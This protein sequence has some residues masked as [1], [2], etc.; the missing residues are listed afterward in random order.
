MHNQIRIS[1][2]KLRMTPDQRL[3]GN[4]GGLDASSSCMDKLL[5]ILHPAGRAHFSRLACEAIR[6]QSGVTEYFLTMSLYLTSSSSM[7][8]HPCCTRKLVEAG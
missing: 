3:N 5:P 1:S 6:G 2:A 4:C 8:G 7:Q